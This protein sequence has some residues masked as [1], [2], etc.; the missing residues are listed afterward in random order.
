MAGRKTGVSP[1]SLD[2]FPVCNKSS[3]IKV[4]IFWVN[5]VRMEKLLILLASMQMLV[6]YTLAETIHIHNKTTVSS[7]F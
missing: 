5:E 2:L 7:K 1:E 4:K 3:A 6:L